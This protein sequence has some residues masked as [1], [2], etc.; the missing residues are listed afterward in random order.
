MADIISSK[1]G[2]LLEI[3]LNRPDHGNGAT[4][5]MAIE[6][7]RLIQQAPQGTQCI[8][9]RGA[10]KDFC[11]GRAVMGSRPVQAPEALAM[12]RSFDAIF[13]CYS[14]IR[15]SP[16]PV[17]A[18]VQGRALGFGCALAAVADIT[19]A[20]EAAQFQVPEMAHNI[21][22]TMVMSSF[23]D[24]VPRKAFIY[25]IYSTAVIDAQRA[26]SFGIVSDVEPAAQLEQAVQKL[27]AAIVKAP[28]PA[29]LGLKEYA[30]TAFDMPVP[31]AIDFARNLHAVINSSSEMRHES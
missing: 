18:V 19:I 16:V 28:H 5:E 6:L 12:K 13:N 15:N 3:T 29:L 2:P 8:V 4:D 11:I 17:I 31:G 26:L 20:E 27:T 23:I 10:G 30:R 24:R 1:N 14:A 7:T 25:L 9:L 21:L 22:P